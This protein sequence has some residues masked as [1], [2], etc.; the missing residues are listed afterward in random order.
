MSQQNALNQ[1]FGALAE[2]AAVPSASAY[3]QARQKLAPELF[4]QL[5]QQV[6]DDFYRLSQDDQ[7]LTRWHGHR[8]LG[9][10]G[11]CLNLPDRPALRAA[12]SVHH[13]QHAGFVQATAVVLYDL[14]N[15]LAL[16]GH[17]GPLSGEKTPLLNRL[18]PTTRV[19]DLL[20]LDRNFADYYL[21]A[22]A[23][24]TERQ[25][26]IRC[27]RNSFAVVQRFWDSAEIDQR[28]ELSLP[29]SSATRRA[30]R[31]AGL[32]ERLPVRLLKFSLPSGETEVLLTTLCDPQT[33]PHDEFY[34]V[35]GRRWKQETY[36]AR[37]K[38]IFELER[39]SGQSEQVIRQDFYGVLFLTTLES[40]L[41]QRAQAT[42]RERDQAR[43]PQ[44]AALVNRA[45]SYVALL[46]QA[47]ALL[48]DGR[49]SAEQ[50]LAR[51][52]RLFQLSPTR[53]REGRH[54]PRR[55]LKHSRSLRH[56]RYRRRLT[57]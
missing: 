14:G 29:Q 18:W 28:V 7:S 43:Q 5:N 47:V 38:Q 9:A 51:L 16:A 22:S 48:L 49:T 46:D 45:V 34:A 25:V 3:C 24:S 8:L 50:A 35:Y 1:L 27:P 55:V 11:T 30:V 54:L 39:F 32:A 12:F 23:L 15:D 19:G 31:A 40:I 13:N 52:E 36:Y 56:Q 41:A 53:Q 6:V 10:D 20:V 42:L 57:A 21:I 33:Y 4:V 44:T 26:L 2:P 37:L 17:L